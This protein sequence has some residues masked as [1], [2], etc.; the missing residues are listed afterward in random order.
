M[1]LDNDPSSMLHQAFVGNCVKRGVFF[2][3]HHNHFIN[4]S[5]TDEDIEFTWDVAREAFKELHT[6]EDELIL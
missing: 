1:R 6:Q 5:L 3:N 4:C 2:T